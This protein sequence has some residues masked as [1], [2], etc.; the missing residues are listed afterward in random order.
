MPRAVHPS[1]TGHQRFMP[2]TLT[3]PKPHPNR[4]ARRY[5]AATTRRQPRPAPRA[6]GTP[7]AVPGLPT[8]QPWYA[9]DDVETFAVGEH[10][11]GDGV[12]TAADLR[13]MAEN[14]RLNSQSRAGKVMPPVVVLKVDVGIDHD[15]AQ[16]VLADAGLPSAG[17]VVA[18]RFDEPTGKFLT[19]WRHVP[20]EVA[21]AI[22]DGALFTVSAEIYDDPPPGVRGKG[23]T[24]RRAVLLGG[25]LPAVKTL[26]RVPMPTPEP[27]AFAELARTTPARPLTRTYR[28]YAEGT[29][30]A[31]A[32]APADTTTTRTDAEDKLRAIGWTDSMIAKLAPLA[33]DEFNA[34]ALEA[35]AAEVIEDTGDGEPTG[36]LDPN[37]PA[38][39]P[40]ADHAAMVQAILTAEADQGNPTHTSDE[41][42]AMPD[43]Q[44]LAL[45]Q[46]L[47]I[48]GY[49]E[50]EPMA[51]A[52]AAPAA[53]KPPTPKPAPAPRPQPEPRPAPGPT[54]PASQHAEAA[55]L[56]AETVRMLAQA[57]AERQRTERA[58][59]AALK[60]LDDREREER[61]REITAFCESERD[62]GRVSPAE[63]DKD[64]NDPAA[65]SLPERLL[66]LDAKTVV[67]KFSD[68]AGKA[69]AWTALEM[70]MDAIRRRSVRRYGETFGQPQKVP[71]E[72]AVQ[73]AA[74]AKFYAERAAAR[75]AGKPAPAGNRN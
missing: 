26:K 5:A 22:R 68:K 71:D 73:K 15:E 21:A 20:G 33:D 57:K 45:C 10:R 14:F 40:F 41:L 25:E 27:L 52:P 24:L 74:I 75:T 58:G 11:D 35:L 65:L 67:H 16:K 53:P 42:D 54:P 3:L 29:P 9:M 18:A 2:G 30:M 13:T 38:P 32:A 55:R 48:S 44:L 1:G 64:P 63:L 46:Q 37:A 59:A 19:S 17:E 47:Q 23:P 4:A 66:L 62:A 8:P 69:V 28:L 49:S 56:Y 43:D 61:R 31:A 50:G 36:T 72:R 6:D 70:E 12:W 7:P 51:A 60:R 34:L 39:A